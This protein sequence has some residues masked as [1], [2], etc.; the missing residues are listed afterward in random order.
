MAKAGQEYVAKDD[1][2]RTPMIGCV[3]VARRNGYDEIELRQ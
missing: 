2:G 3:I 1:H